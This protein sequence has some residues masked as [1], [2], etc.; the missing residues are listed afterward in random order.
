MGIIIA[1]IRTM[2]KFEEIEAFVAIARAGS[3]SKAAKNRNMTKS[4][5]S[6]RLSEL[7]NRIGAQLIMRTTRRL[8]LTDAGTKFLEQA[9]RILDDLAAAESAAGADTGSFQGRLRIAAPLSYGLTKLKPIVSAFIRKHPDLV[10]DIDF[11]DRNVDL[12]EE[13]VDVALRIGTLP[14]STLIARKIIPVSLVAVASPDFWRQ[15]GYPSS[16]SD[17]EHLP[18]LQYTNL[19]RPNVLSFTSPA[20]DKG[21][22]TPPIRMLASNGEFLASM[23]VDGCGFLVEP[24]FILEPFIE[25]GQLE[26]VLERYSWGE[27]NLYLVYPPSRLIAA[28]TRAFSEAVIAGLGH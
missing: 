11:S 15:Q 2:A 17:L 21:S 27:M 25:S 18:L 4:A 7:E 5:L 12:V 19:S 22:I 3:I 20:G 8:N 24:L 13:G 28:K 23:A 10:V 9:E 1:Y 14:D 6:R 26:P 16:P